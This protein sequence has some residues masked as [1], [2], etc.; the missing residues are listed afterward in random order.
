MAAAGAAALS[1]LLGA[2]RAAATAGTLLALACVPGSVRRILEITAADQV[3]RIFDTV[4][5]AVAALSG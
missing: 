2:R 5:D 1:V 4:A 3:L